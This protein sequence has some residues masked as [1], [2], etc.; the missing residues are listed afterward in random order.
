VHLANFSS[1][2][3]GHAFRS[4][5]LSGSV[6]LVLVGTVLPP[7]NYGRQIYH[8]NLGKLQSGIFH[9]KFETG[10]VSSGHIPRGSSGEAHAIDTPICADEA[11]D[12]GRR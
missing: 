11:A 4:F 1:V 10:S 2:R 8:M 5:L 3:S 12:P 7:A 6:P 9:F